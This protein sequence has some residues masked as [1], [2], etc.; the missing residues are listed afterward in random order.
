M[1]ILRVLAA[2]GVVNQVAEEEYTSTPTTSLLIDA[3]PVRDAVSFMFVIFFRSIC[4]SLPK[5]KPLYFSF[6]EHTSVL[7]TL[8]KYL[9]DN[10]F[11]NPDSLIG[12]PYQKAFN[13][14]L[15][16]FDYIQQ[17]P[18]RCRVHD[19][20]MTAQRAGRGEEWFDFFPVELTIFRNL[21][22]N[23]E[24]AVLLVDIGGGVGHDLQTFRAR[25]P[26]V[27]GRLIL[28]ELPH[29]IDSITDISNGIELVKYDF[30]T[31]QPFQ[32]ARV[33]YMRAV[34]HDWPDSCCYRIL[35]SIVSAMGAESRLLLNEC[36]LAEVGGDLFPAQLDIS[37]M[38]QHGSMER[39][40]KQWEKLLGEVGLQ[41]V[42]VHTSKGA[43]PGSESLIEAI[44]KQCDN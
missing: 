30:F 33:Y 34:L 14:K 21:P 23:N 38:M 2:A 11:T 29:V 16:F 41:V 19:S 40:R 32:N 26:R 43:R 12:T 18:E 24:E 35:N 15:P 28:Q 10:G 7:V 8:P 36:V 27:P 9:S 3:S 25:Y 6:D 17:F 37:M 13:T 44:K 20:A 42:D 5:T 39:T 1:R 22:K 4:R 31:P